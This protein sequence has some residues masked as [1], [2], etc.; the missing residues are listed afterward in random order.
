M[1]CLGNI[2]RSPIAHGILQSEIAERG[3]S[4]EVDSAGTS[5]YHNG[6]SPDRRAIQ[7]S[8]NNGIN[9]SQ[10]RSRQLTANDI[11]DYDVIVTMDTNNYNNTLKLIGDS[12]NKSKVKML[13]NYSFPNENRAVPDPYYSGGFEYVYDLIKQAVEDMVMQLTEDK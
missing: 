13:L 8:A 7:V 1:V 9:I 10:Q 6:E 11:L 4:W 5:A 12:D 2:C 3:L